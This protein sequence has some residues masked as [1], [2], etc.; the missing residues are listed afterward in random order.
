MKVFV[1]HIVLVDDPFDDPIYPAYIVCAT[2]KDEAIELVKRELDKLIE[3]F[4]KEKKDLYEAWEQEHYELTGKKVKFEPY[5]EIEKVE[6][7]AK[8][9]IIAV[10]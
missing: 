4:K 8:P 1:I 3:E 5:Y 7:I 10:I 6:E 2:S 9:K